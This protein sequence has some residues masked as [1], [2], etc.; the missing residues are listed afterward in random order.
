MNTTKKTFF[1]CAGAQTDR[2]CNAN[3]DNMMDH[4]ANRFTPSVFRNIHDV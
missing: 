3:R 1:P 2:V 4:I